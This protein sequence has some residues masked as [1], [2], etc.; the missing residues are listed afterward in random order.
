[1]C[2]RMERA[3]LLC[4]AGIIMRNYDD[5]QVE[6]MSDRAE[7]MSGPG[8]EPVCAIMDRAELLCRAGATIMG[9]C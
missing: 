6:Q 2:A 4:G 1:M 5:A 3:E 7:Q 9:K 8:N